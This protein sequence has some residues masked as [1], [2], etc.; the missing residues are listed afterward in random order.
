[1]IVNR[2]MRALPAFIRALPALALAVLLATPAQA[3]NRE[4]IQQKSTAA[5]EKLR[6]HTKE[7]DKLIKRASGVLVFPDVVEMTFGE[8]GRYGE[9]VLLIEGEPA[10]YY[11]TAG[12]PHN[13]PEGEGRKAELILFMTRQALIDFRNTID[14]KVGVS[15]DVTRVHVDDRGRLETSPNSAPVL[16]LSFS[17]KGIL[18]KLDLD[19]TSINRIAR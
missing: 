14:W 2:L 6:K 3:D 10:A 12:K 1:M 11:A 4:A 5:L 13:V 15:R 9:G 7:V 18:G 17:D 16:G 19:G 8:R